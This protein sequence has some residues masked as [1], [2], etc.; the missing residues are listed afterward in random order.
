MCKIDNVLNML[1]PKRIKGGRIVEAY[2]NNDNSIELI[3]WRNE[4]RDEGLTLQCTDYEHARECI[5]KVEKICGAV[6]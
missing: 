1:P 3:V 4:A 5:A 2:R 6:A